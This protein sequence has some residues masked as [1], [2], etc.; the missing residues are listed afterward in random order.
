MQTFSNTQKSL[1]D[2][3]KT[4]VTSPSL[5]IIIFHVVFVLNLFVT[6]RLAKSVDFYLA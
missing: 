2:H 4:P 3:A 5:T 1:D 6:S